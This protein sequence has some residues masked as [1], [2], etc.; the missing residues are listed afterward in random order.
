MPAD[1]GLASNLLLHGVMKRMAL[2]LGL[3][4]CTDP[5]TE[6]RVEPALAT[7]LPLGTT[8][9]FTVTEVGCG[10]DGNDCSQVPH[11]WSVIPD[12]G[13]SVEIS[14][15]DKAHGTFDLRGVMVG[16]TGILVVTDKDLRDE[17]TVTVK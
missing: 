15:V 6:L 7:P 8:R 11:D 10:G 2:V 13:T 12:L 17:A 16:D 1:P 5:P 3:A 9:H 4:A 14:A